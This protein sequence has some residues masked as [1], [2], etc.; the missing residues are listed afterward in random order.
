[1]RFNIIEMIR[2]EDNLIV[3]SYNPVKIT[4]DK[5][6]SKPEI[7]PPKRT[8]DPGIEIVIIWRRCVVCDYWRTSIVIIAVD[9]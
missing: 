9:Y 6:P 8:G 1:M 3:D 2:N 7:P 5:E 4:K